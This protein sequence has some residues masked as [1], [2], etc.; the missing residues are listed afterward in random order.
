[1]S[2][3][4]PDMSTLI[5]QPLALHWTSFMGCPV[6]EEIWKDG[7]KERFYENDRVRVQFK[8]GEVGFGTIVKIDTIHIYFTDWV[9]PSLFAP[10]E[11][12]IIQPVV[13]KYDTQICFNKG[14]ITSLMS[15]PA[16]THED[17]NESADYDD[18]DDDYE[19]YEDE[20][21]EDWLDD[22]NPPEIY[23]F[24]Y[25]SA[26][27][28]KGTHSRDAFLVGERVIVV[29]VD[30]ERAAG[31]ISALKSTFASPKSPKAVHFD[32]WE[33]LDNYNNRPQGNRPQGNRPQHNNVKVDIFDIDHFEH[34]E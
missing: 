5:P 19:D 10:G 26:I 3:D 13:Q 28:Q 7:H 17:D 24:E 34:F 30:G 21:L 20:T 6:I 27:I 15:T 22:D 23:T 32:Q 2:L 25:G 14:D 4:T 8:G 18:L 31:K 29:G 16:L 11:N 12:T 9:E 1:M 33:E